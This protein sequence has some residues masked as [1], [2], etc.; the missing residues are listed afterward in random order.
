MAAGG[1][2][3]SALLLLTVLPYTT[4][5]TTQPQALFFRPMDLPTTTCPDNTAQQFDQDVDYDVSPNRLLDRTTAASSY[6]GTLM[7]PPVFAGRQAWLILRITDVNPDTISGQGAS[8]ELH[9]VFLSNA[10][11]ETIFLGEIDETDIT[12]TP[13]D[14]VF[15]IPQD[16]LTAGDNIIEVQLDEVLNQDPNVSDG[17]NGD[18]TIDSMRV[19][20]GGYY[21]YNIPLVCGFTPVD[22]NATGA[23][24]YRTP[25]IKKGDYATNILIRNPDRSLPT[26]T[27]DYSLYVEF[28]T[29]IP[30]GFAGSINNIDFNDTFGAGV[31]TLDP[32]TSNY[33]SCDSLSELV[34][35]RTG[36]TT[37]EQLLWKGT[38]IITQPIGNGT[39]QTK[40]P[41]DI[42]AVYSYELTVNKIRYQIL[43]DPT[44]KIPRHLI[45]TDL[46][47]V[48]AIS[49]FNQTRQG[50]GAFENL[51]IMRMIRNELVSG[52]GISPAVAERVVLRVIE[53][54]LGTGA[55]QTINHI[56]PTEAPLE[57]P[58][59]GF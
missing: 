9:E 11:G 26:M 47:M 41:L 13:V 54:S 31:G 24:T 20:Y 56:E 45:G 19:C 34:R 50:P 15:Q 46:E 57:S 37:N 5:A 17:N 8:D 59:G 53:A 18:I 55:S 30:I 40:L 42:Q 16:F 23:P 48:V 44:G 28:V 58:I 2:L 32:L 14:L 27:L 21:V 6:S 35:R 49:P 25:A 43:R 38:L 36:A 12:T 1:L 33:T 39:T 52:F 4:A 51:Q 22:L 7:V 29:S 10:N 3:A